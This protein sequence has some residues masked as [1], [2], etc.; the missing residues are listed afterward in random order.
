MRV[1]IALASSSRQLSGVQRHAINV[2]RCLLTTSDVSAVHLIAAPWQQEFLEDCV[3]DSDGRL[4]IHSAAIGESALSRNRWY[5]TRLPQLAA[6][7]KVDIAHLA[8]PAPVKTKAFPCPAVVTLHDLY[9]YDIQENFGFP[10]VLFNRLVLGQCLSGVDAVACVSHGTL[11]RMR[12]FYP[13]LA[14]A[15]AVVISNCVE[16][17]SAATGD[18]SFL[19]TGEKPFLL[20]VA[21]HRRNKNI[22][23]LLRIFKRMLSSG[24]LSRETRLVIIGI[25]GPETKRIL[26][27][28]AAEDL[29]SNVKLV[30]GVS[31][32]ELQWCYRNCE[33]LLAPSIVEGFGLP[34][35]EALLAG[36]RIICSDLPVFREVGGDHCRYIPLGSAAEQAFVDAIC[37]ALS[38]PVPAPVSLPQLSASVIGNQYMKLYQSLQL[39]ERRGC[40]DLRPASMQD[41]QRKA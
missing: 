9:P 24:Q 38:Q 12:H 22:L 11:S 41:T 5:Y 35:A 33:L 29:T 21:Q 28:L 14:E 34:I 17:Y 18:S 19:K 16:S 7:L 37:H 15:K 6:E 30:S 27:F 13:G 20:C 2:A 23:F 31:E 1:V 32:A 10:K 40:A 4:S 3:Q 39:Q 26:H 36:C 8:Y 25:P